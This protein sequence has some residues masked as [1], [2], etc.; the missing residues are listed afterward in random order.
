MQNTL[1][2]LEGGVRGYDV[3]LG[4]A[5]RGAGV[6]GGGQGAAG[7]QQRGGGRGPC[8]SVG[9]ALRSDFVVV[10]GQKECNKRVFLSACFRD[11]FPRS[12]LGRLARVSEFC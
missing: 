3:C 6:L 10:L 7:T 5:G 4:R 2:V 11:R 9:L 8:W 1:T 12:H